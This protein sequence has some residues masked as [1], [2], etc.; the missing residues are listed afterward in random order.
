M[1]NWIRSVPEIF[2]YS[3]FENYWCTIETAVNMKA[4][5]KKSNI[6]YVKPLIYLIY[7]SEAGL[8]ESGKA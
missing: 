1:L 3:K 7:T 4:H 8:K 6:D 5:H 2:I